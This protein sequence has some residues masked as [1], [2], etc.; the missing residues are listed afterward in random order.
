[1]MRYRE[2]VAPG[3]SSA[4]AAFY[5]TPALCARRKGRKYLK[6]KVVPACEAFRCYNQRSESFAYGS[7]SKCSMSRSSLL[8]IFLLVVVLTAQLSCA[9]PGTGSGRAA[10]SPSPGQQAAV[11]QVLQRDEEAIRGSARIHQ[12]T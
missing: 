7:P 2:S 4:T 12:H 6:I 5:V 11:D 1:M 10:A 8:P 3:E 9:R